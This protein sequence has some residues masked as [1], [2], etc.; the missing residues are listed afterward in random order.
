MG[1]PKTVGHYFTIVALF[2]SKLLMY[3]SVETNNLTIHIVGTRCPHFKTCASC[4]F[5]QRQQMKVYYLN[6]LSNLHKLTNLSY[7]SLESID[8]ELQCVRVNTLDALLD[9]MVAVLILDTLENVAIQ[10]SHYLHLLI[11]RYGLQSL[12]YHTTA[13]HLQS[14]RQNMASHLLNSSEH[15]LN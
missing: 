7:L 1:F 9:N 14:Q 13:I 15:Y 4:L 2:F 8:N 12:L 10:L 5:S 3:K 11:S 6:N